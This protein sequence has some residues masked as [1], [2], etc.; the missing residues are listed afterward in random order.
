[1]ACRAAWATA[2]IVIKGVAAII[3]KYWMWCADTAWSIIAYLQVNLGLI[4]HVYGAFQM[5]CECTRPF[6]GDCWVDAR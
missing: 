2:T 6:R 1:M 4:S 3:S 5:N